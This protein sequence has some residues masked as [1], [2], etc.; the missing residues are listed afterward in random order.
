MTA[1]VPVDQSE[2][3]RRFV[4]KRKLEEEDEAQVDAEIAAHLKNVAL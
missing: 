1:P 3:E 4:I 2:P